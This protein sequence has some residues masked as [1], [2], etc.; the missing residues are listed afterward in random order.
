MK[1]GE[2]AKCLLL[3]PTSRAR[4]L[5]IQFG[6][7]LL[8]KCE[9]CRLKQF[10]TDIRLKSPATLLG[11]WLLQEV[12]QTEGRWR[13]PWFCQSKS[14]S[15]YFWSCS[16]CPQPDD[17]QRGNV[18]LC[19]LSN[20]EGGSPKVFTLFFTLYMTT[21]KPYIHRNINTRRS[22]TYVGNVRARLAN[23][24]ILFNL[25]KKVETKGNKTL[26]G[27]LAC[28]R[29]TKVHGA[30]PGLVGLQP[31]HA[32][33]GQLVVRRP[34]RA[35]L[36]DLHHV[37]RVPATLDLLRISVT[38]LLDEN[39]SCRQ[40]MTVLCKYVQIYLAYKYIHPAKYSACK[41]IQLTCETMV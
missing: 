38:S 23:W 13:Y 20:G 2:L 40:Q 12:E 41:D 15:G 11:C 32:G 26:F 18:F 24:S 9:G 1:V 16:P 7:Q 21:R 37:D 14:R 31:E 10:I 34:A 25:R 4:V 29:A 35:L 3:V 28:E 39:D 5:F 22:C 27:H 19:A 30:T 6:Q 17:L 8:L 36:L 33:A